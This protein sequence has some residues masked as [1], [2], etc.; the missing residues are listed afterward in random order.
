MSEQTIVFRADASETIGTGHVMR[1]IALA[2]ELK[3]RDCDIHFIIASPSHSITN[4]MATEGFTLH[5]VSA[6][7]GTLNDAEIICGIART[8]SASWIIIDGYQFNGDFQKLLKTR[9]FKLLCVDDYGHAHQY[10]ADIVLN[11]NIN[12]G[13]EVMYPNNPRIRFLLGSKYALLREE[14]IPWRVRRHTNPEKASNILVTLGG[15]DPE[16]VTLHII[17]VL[18]QLPED[19]FSIKVIIG[20]S[21]PHLKSISQ[22]I[23]VSRHA[24]ELVKDV[25][26]MGEYFSWADLAITA[27]GST[28]LELAYVGVPMI[29][30]VIADNQKRGCE[31]LQKRRAAVNLGIFNRDLDARILPCVRKLMKSLNLRNELS[32]N[33][34]DLVDGRGAERVGDIICKPNIIL[35]KATPK[36]CWTV[37]YWM[38]DSYM[39]EVSFNTKPILWDEHMKWF[40]E[41]IKDLNTLYLIIQTRDNVSVGQVRFDID[42]NDA[43]ISILID[44][45]YRGRN[46]GMQAIHISAERLFGSTGVNQVHAYIKTSSTTSCKAFRKAGFCYR[47]TLKRGHE[48]AYHMILIRE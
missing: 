8:L 3:K 17:Q 14:I 43:T 25:S 24:I 21:N 39:P 47:E 15:S 32:R 45:K 22:V 2:Q 13:E 16:N 26:N 35:K 7:P 44:P 18:Q 5:C 12:A 36:D 4:R 29:T 1:C 11:P 23:G 40:L 38:N 48:K 34:I 6:E 33:A 31:S 20:S 41:K 46:I 28:T 42:G 30:I 37:F 9:G 27:G 10:H 19:F